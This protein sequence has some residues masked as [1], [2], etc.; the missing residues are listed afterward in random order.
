MPISNQWWSLTDGVV[1]YDKEESGV[2]ELGNSSEVVIYVGSADNL[3]RRLKE[4]INA[5]HSDC[6]KK[7]AAKYRL[8]YTSRHKA[9]EKELYDPACAH[10]RQ[11]ADVQCNR[12]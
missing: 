9:R 10:V 8:E 3:R 12:S 2:Y 7:N 4:H 1:A 6:V 5:S 11:A